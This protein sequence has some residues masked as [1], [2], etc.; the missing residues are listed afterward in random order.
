MSLSGREKLLARYPYRMIV[1]MLFSYI[2]L[3]VAL[4]VLRRMLK[5]EEAIIEVVPVGGEIAADTPNE[6]RMLKLHPSYEISS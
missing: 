5:H 2:M 6:E 3:A 4:Q 1:D